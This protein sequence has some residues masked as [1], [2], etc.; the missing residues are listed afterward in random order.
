M[1]V[2]DPLQIWSY[3]CDDIDHKNFTSSDIEWTHMGELWFT[4][5]SNNVQ[6][7]DSGNNM[8]NVILETQTAVILR[9]YYTSGMCVCMC[10]W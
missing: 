1:C 3:F 9:L 6:I 10:V 2:D 7:Y 8:C 5:Y 4:K